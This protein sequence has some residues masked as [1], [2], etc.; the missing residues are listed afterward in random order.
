MFTGFLVMKKKALFLVNIVLW[1]GVS[2]DEKVLSRI[3]GSLLLAVGLV[4]ILLP[5]I[6]S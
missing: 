6:L 2:G 5:F 4:T 3:F 1:N